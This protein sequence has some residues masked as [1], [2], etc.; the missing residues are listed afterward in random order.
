MAKG[1]LGLDTHPREGR[2][3]KTRRANQ[4]LPSGKERPFSVFVREVRSNADAF[5]ALID[6]DRATPT[7]ALGKVMAAQLTL[8]KHRRGA[9]KRDLDRLVRAAVRRIDK[10]PIFALDRMRVGD[11][12]PLRTALKAL[13]SQF[14]AAVTIEVDPV[15]RSVT[16]RKKNRAR[17]ALVDHLI[18]EARIEIKAEKEEDADGDERS[19]RVDHPALEPRH[20]PSAA[21]RDERWDGDEERVDR[22]TIKRANEAADR[23]ERRNEDPAIEGVDPQVRHEELVRLSKLI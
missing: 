6:H 2:E 7:R 22:L 12:N 20:R 11:L 15:T 19:L 18:R 5:L 17:S 8:R 9:A 3:I 4:R 1:V 10:K 23:T 13:R 16:L 14:V 21:A